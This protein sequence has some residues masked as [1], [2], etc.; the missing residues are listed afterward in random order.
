[1]GY[2]IKL[3]DVI[4]RQNSFIGFAHF[5]EIQFPQSLIF[6][7]PSIRIFRIKS[8]DLVESLDG[9]FTFAYI[10]KTDSFVIPSV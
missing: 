1:M 4:E 2:R 7:V 3:V 9:I 8:N 10:M 5:F 6:V